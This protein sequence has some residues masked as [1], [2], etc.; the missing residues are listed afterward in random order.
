MQRRPIHRGQCQDA[1]IEPEFLRCKVFTTLWNQLSCKMSFLVKEDPFPEVPGFEYNVQPSHFHDASL[2]LKKILQLDPN[3]Q[4]CHVSMQVTSQRSK[5]SEPGGVL[6]ARPG[7]MTVSNIEGDGSEPGSQSDVLE[8]SETPDAKRRKTIISSAKDAHDEKQDFQPAQLQN[9]ARLANFE[10][11]QR[12]R[13][14]DI[15]MPWE[16]GPLAP[17]FRGPMPNVPPVKTLVPPTVG[18][19]DTLAPAV[20]TKQDTPVQVGPISKFAAKRIAAAKCVVPEDEMLARCLNQIK[21]LLLLDLQG[22][23]VGLTLCNLAGG[24]DEISR[25]FAGAQGLLCQEGHGDDPQKDICFVDTSR[26]DAGQRAD[27]GMGH[28]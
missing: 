19:V 26:L 9:I 23:E 22:T 11:M 18:L 13:A 24:L 12:V 17:I 16:R 2:L 21:N 3:C 27:T 8:T 1:Q 10:A 7:V 20:L 6:R 14:H 25:R 5:V 15:K 28:Q 4:L